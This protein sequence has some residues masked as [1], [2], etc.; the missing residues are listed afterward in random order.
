M[1]KSNFRDWTSDRIDEVFGTKQLDTH[2]ALGE[3]MNTQSD[4]LDWEN[5]AIAQIQAPLIK[6]VIG[7]NEAELENKFISPMFVLAGVYGDEFGYFLERDLAA[8]LDGYELSGRVDGM[9]ATGVRN[10]KKPFFCLNEYKRFTDPDGEP[11]GQALISMLVAQELNELSDHVLYGCY[12]IGSNW[13]F[14]V[15]QERKYAIS[16]SFSADGEDIYDIFRILKGLK[17]IVQRQIDRH[18]KN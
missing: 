18:R 3:W 9:I 7:W 10:P 8:T 2:S 14:M 11:Q 15:L 13:Y 16:S 1:I 17:F 5:Q 6:G 12:V 4:I